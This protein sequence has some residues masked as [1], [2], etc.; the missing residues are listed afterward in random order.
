MRIVTLGV[1]LAKNVFQLCGVDAKGKVVLRRRVSRDQLAELA[2]TL[3]PC[4]IAIE[5]C[6]S[7]HHWAREFVKRGHTVRMISPQFVKPFVKGNKNDGNDAQ[8]IV[9]A[10]QRPTMR[11][12]PV[13]TIE[14]QDIQS[15]HRARSR[16]VNN[17]TGLVSQMRGI[18]AERG[19]VFPKSI[20]RAR[21]EI[22][23]IVRD[24]TQEL[25]SLC[26]ELLSD[27]LEQLAQLDARIASMDR[28]IATVFR[29]SEPCQ[30]LAEI[31]G[32]G[33]MTATAIV[34]AIGNGSDFKNGRHLAAWLGLV[35]RQHSSGERHRLY[36]ISK[37]GDKHLRTM[38]IHGARAVVRIAPTKNDYRHKWVQA[39]RER[40]GVNRTIVAVANKNA[41]IIWSVLAKNE[42]YRA[43]P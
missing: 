25:S 23:R 22:P 21:R 27:L 28:R 32:V 26:R 7:A 37:R 3:E 17:R 11:F 38:L 31:S 33:P 41:R 2:A 40:R 42:H 6:P 14:Q 20:T 36:G 24:L 19:I 15:L 5:A 29:D 12:V 13:K 43:A 16:L 10:A 34:A 35:P 8:A 9:E 1:D 39:L 30:R 4:T 18:L